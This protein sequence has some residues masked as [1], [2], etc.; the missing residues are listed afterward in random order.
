MK[1]IEVM[2]ALSVL[3]ITGCGLTGSKASMGWEYRVYRPATV[4]NETAAIVEASTG[5][6]KAG[7]VGAVTGPIQEGAFTHGTTMMRMGVAPQHLETFQGPVKQRLLTC[8]EWCA[9]QMSMQRTAVP[10][11]ALPMPRAN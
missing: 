2:I 8:E 10:A 3:C 6:M 9:L 1:T 11:N 5:S 4:A 7:S